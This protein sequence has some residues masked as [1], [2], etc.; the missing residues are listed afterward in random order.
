MAAAAPRPRFGRVAQRTAVPS[1]LGGPTVCACAQDDPVELPWRSRLALCLDYLSSLSPLSTLLVVFLCVSPPVFYDRVFLPCWE[2]YDFEAAVAHEVGHVLGFGHPDESPDSNLVASCALNN[3]TCRTPFECAVAQK[4]TEADGSI[5]H[6]FTR[7]QPKT[8]LSEADLQ[9]LHFLYPLCDDMLPQASRART[10]HVQR[11]ALRFAQRVPA[12]KLARSAPTLAHPALAPAHSMCSHISHR[13]AA[14][15]VHQDPEAVGLA[16]AGD[17]GGRA[18][19]NR[20]GP[21]PAPSL[22]P[23]MPR[24]PKDA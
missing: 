20:G 19:C 10:P 5:M 21:D 9:G 15:V 22:V 2:C 18:V 23:P 6:S 11:R 14:R 24:A 3:A 8:C 1:A 17:R 4:Y 13:L 7:R 12:T 16:A